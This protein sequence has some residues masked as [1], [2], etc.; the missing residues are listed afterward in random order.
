MDFA[1]ERW[2]MRRAMKWVMSAGPEYGRSLLE[3]NG[4][5]RWI[6]HISFVLLTPLVQYHLPAS[7]DLA[8]LSPTQSPLF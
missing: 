4:G 2:T 1:D 8:G 3:E 6:D 5:G 7:H